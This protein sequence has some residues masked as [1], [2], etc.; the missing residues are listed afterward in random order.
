MKNVVL[1][2][3][4]EERNLMMSCGLSIKEAQM[5]IDLGKDTAF[6]DRSLFSMLFNNYNSYR[7]EG[8]VEGAKTYYSRGYIEGRESTHMLNPI[9]NSILANTVNNLMGTIGINFSYH[10][11]FNGLFMNRINNIIG[12][13]K[14]IKYELTDNN[15]L[16]RNENILDEEI[17]KIL[18]KAQTEIE[19]LLQNMNKE[20]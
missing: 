15:T 17:I 18:N 16:I 20:K 12:Q 10:T 2:L 3:S 5:R 14:F 1:Q 7:K 4:E 13:T 6:D 9:D 11:A 19:S 8:Y